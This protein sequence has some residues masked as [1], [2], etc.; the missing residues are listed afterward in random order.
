MKGAQSLNDKPQEQQSCTFSILTPYSLEA[1]QFAHSPTLPKSEAVAPRYSW[2][3]GTTAQSPYRCSD[4]LPPSRMSS[5]NDVL[6]QGPSLRPSSA[7][8][9]EGETPGKLGIRPSKAHPAVPWKARH[10][11]PYGQ[12]MGKTSKRC[13]WLHVASMRMSPWMNG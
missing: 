3:T 7:A 13:I 2:E 4:V 1:R 10:S 12:T 11:F 9:R 6:T 5:A 8:E